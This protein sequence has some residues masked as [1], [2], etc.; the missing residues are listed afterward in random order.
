[1][2]AQLSVAFPTSGNEVERSPDPA[3]RSFL[4]PGLKG[5]SAGHGTLVA[6][7]EVEQDGVHWV[8]GAVTGGSPKWIQKKRERGQKKRQQDSVP[9]DQF[10]AEGRW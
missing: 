10:A 4:T 9:P 2:G 1:M 3:V 7:L 5:H 8:L 6:A